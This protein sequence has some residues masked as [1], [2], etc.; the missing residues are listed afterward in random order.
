M[1]IHKDDILHVSF[2]TCVFPM[3][4]LYIGLAQ[5]EKHEITSERNSAQKNQI[6]RAKSSS[7]SS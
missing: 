5:Y 2:P 7:R 6:V 1:Q 4:L 3:D